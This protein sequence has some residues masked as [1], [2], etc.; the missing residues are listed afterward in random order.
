MASSSLYLIDE[1]DALERAVLDRWVHDA[2]G[3]SSDLVVLPDLRTSHNRAMSQFASRLEAA[4]DPLL[5]PLR[6][7]W[8]PKE[9]DG[10]QTARPA[11]SRAR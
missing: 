6:V 4:G 11:R 7:A 10:Q 5:T 3:A 2:G 9:H 1:V 8:L